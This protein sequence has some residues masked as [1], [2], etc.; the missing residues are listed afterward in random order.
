MML[1]EWHLLI[2]I[3]LSLKGSLIG[4][5]LVL[6]KTYLIKMGPQGPLKADLMIRL[7]FEA[8]LPKAW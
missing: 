7:Y 3:G 4:Q 2:D 8:L 5:N 1:W 6:E